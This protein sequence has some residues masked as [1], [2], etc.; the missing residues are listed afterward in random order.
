MTLKMETAGLSEKWYPPTQLLC[1]ATMK[2][3]DKVVPA[4]NL[5]SLLELWE[6]G[7]GSIHVF[8]SLKL[9]G[10]EWSTTH[11]DCFTPRTH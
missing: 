8:I 6:N 4:L 3:G 7:G 2:V 5:L 10:G 1:V 9:D 11:P